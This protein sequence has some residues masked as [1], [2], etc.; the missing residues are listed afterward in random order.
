MIEKI[1]VICK[2]KYLGYGNNAQPIKKGLCCNLC[3]VTKVIPAR[4]KRSMNVRIK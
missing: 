1:C 4:M 3:N 2:N